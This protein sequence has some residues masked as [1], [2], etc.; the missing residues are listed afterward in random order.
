[1][2]DDLT[3]GILIVNS[4][5]LRYLV[6]Y[7]AY[8]FIV[9]LPYISQSTPLF[10]S[11][12]GPW[13]LSKKFVGGET[14]KG[15]FGSFKRH[16]DNECYYGDIGE[17]EYVKVRPCQDVDKTRVEDRVPKMHSLQ[18]EVGN[19]KQLDRCLGNM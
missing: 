11:I 17:R 8:R 15:S 3:A 6:R 1:V 19:N 9:F 13:R 2:E 16:K 4:L 10:A 7:Q 14:R 18:R 12:V 5:L